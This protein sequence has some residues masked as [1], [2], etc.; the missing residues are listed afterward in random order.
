MLVTIHTIILSHIHTI[1]VSHIHYFYQNRLS[2]FC[3]ITHTPN[4]KWADL[5]VTINTVC[6]SINVFIGNLQFTISNHNLMTLL[7]ES[8]FKS[9]E[10]QNSFMTLLGKDIKSTNL[11]VTIQTLIYMIHNSPCLAIF[12]FDNMCYWK[13]FFCV[14]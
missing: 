5:R 3:D 8:Q 6:E 11:K 4:T 2:H 9:L 12:T 7:C 1:I 14:S 13:M 10:I